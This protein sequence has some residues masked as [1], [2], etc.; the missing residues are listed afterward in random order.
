[1]RGHV[2][3][4]TKLQWLEKSNTLITAGKDKKISVNYLN[5][6]ESLIT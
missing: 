1:M 4:V 3:G 2:G 5:G 6:K